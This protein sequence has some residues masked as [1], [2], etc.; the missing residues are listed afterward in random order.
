[1][2]LNKILAGSVLSLLPLTGLAESG[3]YIGLGYG[4]V[5]YKGSVDIDGLVN[6][7]YAEIPLRPIDEGQPIREGNR[8]ASED[9]SDSA[10]KVFGGYKFNRFL[11]LELAYADLGSG[12]ATVLTDELEALST[13]GEGGEGV[14]RG[15]QRTNFSYETQIIALSG[16]GT[17]PI[18]SWFR[19]FGKL[20]LT[21]YDSESSR[22][23]LTAANKTVPGEASVDASDSRPAARDSESGTSWLYG[24][25]AGITLRERWAI[26]LEYESYRDID[27]GQFVD[28][29]SVDMLSV[30][31][32]YHF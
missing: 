9:D 18:G 26:D 22:S 16:R 31:V 19:L 15:S 17:L 3:A 8:V 30:S 5:D 10:W 24:L 28:K 27:F 11:A 23:W 20:G 4:E 14:Y 25:G 1:M 13:A 2:K 32:H 12:S 7:T 21:Y 6:Q 29:D